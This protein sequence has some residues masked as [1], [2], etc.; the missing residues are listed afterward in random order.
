M[1]KREIRRGDAGEGDESGG[2]GERGRTSYDVTLSTHTHQPPESTQQPTPDQTATFLSQ[3]GQ[4]TLLQ[5]IDII[6][7]LN[8]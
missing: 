2:L 3:L 1:V 6:L 4:H 7:Y 5:M 8:C